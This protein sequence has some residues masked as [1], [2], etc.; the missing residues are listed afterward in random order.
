MGEPGVATATATVL[1][2]FIAQPSSLNRR[3]HPP[4]GPPPVMLCDA[5]LPQGHIRAVLLPPPPTPR[6]YVL[7][8]SPAAVPASVGLGGPRRSTRY[9]P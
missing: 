4:V 1:L 5:R 3:N 7:A 6:A 9:G 2:P 8:C